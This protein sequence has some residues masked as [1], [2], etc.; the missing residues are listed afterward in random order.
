MSQNSINNDYKRIF[1]WS[2]PRCV[3]TAFE[4]TFSQ[5]PDTIIVHE[6][7]TNCYFFSRERKSSLHGDCEELLN[8]DRNQAIQKIN[9]NC[10]PIVFCK[11][12]TFQGLPYIDKNFLESFI[13]TFIIRHPIEVLASIKKL[14]PDVPKECFGFEQLYQIWTIVTQSLGQ[15]PIVIEANDFRRNPEKILQCYCEKLG[16]EFMPQMLS[17]KNGK[18][19]KW[20]LYENETQAKWH[21]T[22]ESSTKIFA[23]PI[24][25]TKIEVPPEQ[26]EMI[27]QATKIYE[28]LS[29]FSL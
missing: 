8:Y 20:Q 29:S 3:S 2:P 17:W 10:A 18:L 27:E 21:K 24:A 6:P 14:E 7:F 13:N 1:L 26:V 23:P 22:L 9:S 15:M 28:K 12:L 11:E 5:R 25:Q 16:I 4:K 19:T